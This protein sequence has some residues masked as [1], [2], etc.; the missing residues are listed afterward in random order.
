MPVATFDTVEYANALKAAG[1]PD[2]QAEA[3]ATVLSKALQVNLM[4]LAT[5]DDLKQLAD[6]VDEKIG[7]LRDLLD[8]RSRYRHQFGDIRVLAAARLR[9]LNHK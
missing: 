5:K 7:H 3:Q 8:D 1:V 6:K 9:A 2:K 4:D